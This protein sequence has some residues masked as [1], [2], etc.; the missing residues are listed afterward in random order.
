MCRADPRLLVGIGDDAAVLSSGG[1][2]DT[3]RRLNSGNLVVTTDLLVEDVHFT[4]RYMSLGDIGYKALA[5]SLSDIAAMG[6]KPAWVFGNL[7][8]PRGTSVAAIDELLD[9]IAAAAEPSGV[10][11]AGGDTVAAPQW[12]IG[13]TVMGE[14]AGMP[15]VRSGAQS[16]DLVWHSGVLG[17]SQVGLNRLWAGDTG[18]ETGEQEA[19]VAHK[20]PVARVELGAFLQAEGLASACLDL[21]DSLAQCLLLLATASD[22]GL[23]L[24]FDNYAFAPAV[25]GFRQGLRRWTAG[26]AAA[27]S[28]PRRCNPDGKPGRFTSLA[29]YVLASAED[30]ELLF[31]APPAAT[32]R[33][34]AG[35]PLPLTRL[36]TVVA[37][38]EGCHYR[39]EDGRTREL[40]RVGFDH[41]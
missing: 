13:F 35:S 22:V 19:T 36:G 5:V 38:G 7:G 16:G 20:R 33:L 3:A 4:R 1:R 30:F 28:V 6:G 25:A 41:L 24:D 11:L 2:P 39:A 31:T 37:A 18:N 32:A 29:E 15:L 21:S 10:V 12:I 9:G 26:G 8:V 17:L 40:T 14:V 23:A 34:L 27:F